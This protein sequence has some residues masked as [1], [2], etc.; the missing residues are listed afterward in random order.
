MSP[1][2][3]ENMKTDAQ[4]EAVIAVGLI[5]DSGQAVFQLL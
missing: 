3:C 1:G 4:I 2:V 5:V